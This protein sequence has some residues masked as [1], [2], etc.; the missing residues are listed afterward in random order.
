MT[1]LST[2][3]LLPELLIVT[4]FIISFFR[5]ILWSRLDANI[6][7]SSEVIINF[8]RKNLARNLE[9]KTKNS[10]ICEQEDLLVLL[11]SDLLI[12]CLLKVQD[13]MHGILIW[14]VRFL[15]TDR[16]RKDISSRTFLYSK[17]RGIFRNMS[18]MSKLVHFSKI[19]NY[20]LK[21]IILRCLIGFWIRPGN[22]KRTILTDKS[23]YI[24]GSV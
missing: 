21:T 1:G 5:V 19:V 15:F 11:T 4:I 16:M 12:L 2:V 24:V 8:S 23:S 6:K 10:S 22:L 9:I 18:Q 17:I 3:M 13:K 20:F 7:F 14:W